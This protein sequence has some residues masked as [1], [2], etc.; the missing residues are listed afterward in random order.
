MYEEGE[1]E[2][3]TEHPEGNYSTNSFSM[4]E[5]N[6]LLYTLAQVRIIK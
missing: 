2:K 5:M 4:N 3:K 6:D 1:E